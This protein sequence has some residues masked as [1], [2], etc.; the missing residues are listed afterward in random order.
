MYLLYARV[1]VL[2]CIRTMHICLL[3]TG[4]GIWVGKSLHFSIATEKDHWILDTLRP[5]RLQDCLCFSV[6]YL[7]AT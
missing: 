1:F 6:I 2:V 7:F 5:L 3:Y 4:H